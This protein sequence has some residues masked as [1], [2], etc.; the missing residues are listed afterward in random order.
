MSH[1]K[2]IVTLCTTLARGFYTTIDSLFNTLYSLSV[3]VLDI[4][5]RSHQST[6]RPGFIDAYQISTA[7]VN[8]TLYTFV[9]VYDGRM[10]T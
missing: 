3:Q 6:T 1:M 8:F 9:I 5:N 10:N 7:L 4:S 2:S